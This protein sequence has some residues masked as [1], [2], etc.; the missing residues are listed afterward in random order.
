MTHYQ[1]FGGHFSGYRKECIF[2]SLYVFTSRAQ[3]G[4]IQL[5]WAVELLLLKLCYGSKYDGPGG[6]GVMIFDM[7][8]KTCVDS[9]NSKARKCT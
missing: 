9:S 6:G 8:I 7:G 2:I 3:L 4:P 1:Y 5:L